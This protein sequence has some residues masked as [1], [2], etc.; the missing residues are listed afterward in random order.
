MVTPGSRA[1]L[2]AQTKETT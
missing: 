2:N 1:A